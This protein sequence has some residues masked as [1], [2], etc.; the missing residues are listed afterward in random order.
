MKRSAAELASLCR[1]L[2]E[3]LELPI[4]ER[5][6]W[7]ERLEAANE[8][9]KTTLRKMLLDASESGAARMTGVGKYMDAAVLGAVSAA[10]SPELR[11][12]ASIGPYELIREIG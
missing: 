6:T 5:A 12:G 10:V 8:E 4:E 2:D 7:I 3:G 9:F 1:L 11:A